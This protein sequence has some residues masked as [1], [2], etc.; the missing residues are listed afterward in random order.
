MPARC[1]DALKAHRI[2]QIVAR[3]SAGKNWCENNLVF[4]SRFGTPLDS[5][6]VR[7]AFR[8]VIGDAGLQAAE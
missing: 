2:R 5:H 8:K 1:V 4:A 7:R 6:N 3:Q